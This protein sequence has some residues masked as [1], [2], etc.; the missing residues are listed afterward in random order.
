MPNENKVLAALRAADE[1]ARVEKQAGQ[2]PQAAFAKV[3]DE[4]KTL[5]FAALESFSEELCRAID[6]GKRGVDLGEWHQPYG[7]YAEKRKATFTPPEGKKP[8]C[9]VPLFERAALEGMMDVFCEAL[10]IVLKTELEDRITFR[11]H[12]VARPMF[13]PGKNAPR[14]EHFALMWKIGESEQ[15]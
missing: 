14:R 15:R 8:S 1:K 7:G 2:G 9:L 13:K 5:I 3:C 11:R 10:E 12:N 6:A 4:Y